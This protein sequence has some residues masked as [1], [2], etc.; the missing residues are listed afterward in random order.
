MSV[1]TSFF[2]DL[3]ET[4]IAQ[5]HTSAICRIVKFDSETMR[6]TVQPLRKVMLANGES[7]EMPIIEHVPVSC[8][9]AGGFVIRPPYREGDVVLVV[10][11]ERAIDTIMQTGDVAEPTY[12]RKH[13]ITDAI[14]VSALSPA[15]VP[16]PGDHGDDLVIAKDDF[17]ARIVMKTNGDIEIA[18]SGS[19]NISGEEINLN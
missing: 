15:P 2:R 17:S 4:R 1:G 5:I 7:V 12:R 8:P 6:A 9:R 11:V 18:T 14:V 13:D 10:F 19:V 16:L 3:M